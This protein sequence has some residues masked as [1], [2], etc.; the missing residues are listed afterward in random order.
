MEIQVGTGP[1][2]RMELGPGPK[3]HLRGHLKAKELNP[4]VDDLYE[5]VDQK[6]IK[7]Q[8]KEKR[9]KVSSPRIIPDPE[10]HFEPP[11]NYWHSWTCKGLSVNEID[12]NN[13]TLLMTGENRRKR[14]QTAGTTR[15]SSVK[16][17][18][19]RVR[20]RSAPVQ[21]D[22]RKNI[23][24]D[25]AFSESLWQYYVFLLHK[26]NHPKIGLQKSHIS[27]PLS[28]RIRKS[29]IYHN[30]SLTHGQQ[31]YLMEKCHV[32][33]MTETKLSHKNSYLQVLSTRLQAGLND[34]RDLTKYNLYVRA[35][36]PTIR[37]L[38]TGYFT[39]GQKCHQNLTRTRSSAFDYLGVKTNDRKVGSLSAKKDTIP[40]KKSKQISADFKTT[41]KPNLE[42]I[43]V[44]SS[45]S[46]KVIP[47]LPSDQQQKLTKPSTQ[48]GSSNLTLRLRYE[49]E[50]NNIPSSN[51]ENKKQVDND[52]KQSITTTSSLNDQG[53][54]FDHLRS[55]R[56]THTAK[57]RRSR[58]NDDKFL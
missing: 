11:T 51:D 35:G 42:Q 30:S 29:G 32:Y 10:R 2:M 5:Y 31:L 46:N 20:C 56:A 57:K 7:D 43:H 44:T 28:R 47:R 15:P 54:Q 45:R 18:R 24:F 40:M 25:P 14:P 49:N 50:K 55:R 16:P 53:Q 12:E 4:I 34:P 58:D 17:V 41:E 21:R 39:N 13:E 6:D 27:E 38:N 22:R 8:S 52:D 1:K 9:H 19:S 48:N 33:D 3:S 36:R 23:D 37:P 26:M